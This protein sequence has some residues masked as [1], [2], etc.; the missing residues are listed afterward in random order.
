MSANQKLFWPALVLAASLGAQLYSQEKANLLSC[1]THFQARANWAQVLEADPSTVEFF[2]IRAKTLWFSLPRD[3]EMPTGFEARDCK[4]D[5]IRLSVT[6]VMTKW[7]A[8]GQ[9][10][11]PLPTCME[12]SF[13]SSCLSV[14]E[15]AVR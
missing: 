10:Y 3:C 4:Y 11:E 5:P 2:A 13:C 14:H 8:A 7:A 9:G 6:D 1:S 12:D 15:E